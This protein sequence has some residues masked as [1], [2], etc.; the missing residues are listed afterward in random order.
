MDLKVK[1]YVKHNG[2]WYEPGQELKKVKQEDGK[3]LIE[4]G[5][6][7][8]IVKAEERKEVPKEPKE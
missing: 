5:V 6:A 8:E 7:T 4:T 1:G 3:R 2:K